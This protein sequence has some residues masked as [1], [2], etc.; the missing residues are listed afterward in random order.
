MTVEKAEFE[1]D[2]IKAIEERLRK[3][4]EVIRIC[5]EY[6]EQEFTCGESI[7][8]QYLKEDE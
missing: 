5:A 3:A 1:S 2:H 8:Q 4:E 6:D 7:A